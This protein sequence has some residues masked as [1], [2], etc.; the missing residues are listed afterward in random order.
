MTAPGELYW[1]FGGFGVAIGLF[2]FGLMLGGLYRWFVGDSTDV[3]GY[4][5]FVVYAVILLQ[6]MRFEFGIGQIASNLVKQSLFACVFLWLVTETKA[7][8]PAA[9]EGDS[10]LERSEFWTLS[11]RL[12]GGTPV[13]FLITSRVLHAT[14]IRDSALAELLADTTKSSSVYR[15]ALIF[16]RRFVESSKA[17]DWSRRTATQRLNH[18]FGI[19]KRSITY[20]MFAQ[21]R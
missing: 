5:S 2:L 12:L 7:P 9:L 1:N 19:A 18:F 13:M 11:Q 10:I 14:T 20:R 21:L 17:V 16:N 4:V 15:F 3:P 8:K 6:V